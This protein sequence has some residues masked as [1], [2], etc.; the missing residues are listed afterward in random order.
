MPRWNHEMIPLLY[1]MI[2]IN[3]YFECHHGELR[4]TS[5]GQNQIC[6]LVDRPA[7]GHLMH[8]GFTGHRLLTLLLYKCKSWHIK[9]ERNSKE[10]QLPRFVFTSIKNHCLHSA[11]QQMVPPV[12]FEYSFYSLFYGAWTLSTHNWPQWSVR[13]CS[14]NMHCLWIRRSLWDQ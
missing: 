8:T 9:P 3:Q 2:F 6:H 13:I 4:C 7:I 5:Q 12:S 14:I 11:L 1:R 10:W